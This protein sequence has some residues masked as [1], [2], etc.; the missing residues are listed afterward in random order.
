MALFDG[1]ADDAVAAALAMLDGLASINERRA[2]GGLEPLAMEIGVHTG[3]LMLGT[4]GGEGRLDCTVV[5]D[6]A[7]LAARVE[8]MTAQY[9]AT[10]LIS[11]QTRDALGDQT[12]CCLRRLDRVQAKGKGAVVDIFEVLDDDPPPVR[13][14]KERVRED[15]EAALEAYL[16]GDF[17]AAAAGFQK[18]VETAP[19]DTASKVLLCR[20]EQ[21]RDSPP[22][23]W[24][25]HTRL[26]RK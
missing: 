25:G 17:E 20:A 18:C 11:G 21:L 3:P 16:A 24:P 19:L 4:I 1:G 26:L 5:G 10:L 13:A 22:A 7:N 6:P 9:G 15:Y 14:Q 2:E 23:D 12:A 8:G